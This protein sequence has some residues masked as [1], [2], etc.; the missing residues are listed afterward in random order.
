M[1][2]SKSNTGGTG[3]AWT[4]FKRNATLFAKHGGT[5][6]AAKA[7]AGYVAAMGG[8]AAAVAAAT[9][10]A[11][12]GQSL[13]TF[14]VGSSG[15]TGIVGGLEAVGLQ[16]LVGAD[17]F[18]V[19]SELLLEF[20]GSGGDLEAQAARSALLDV[21]DAILPED[22]VPLESVRLD[23][24]A[25]ADALCRYIAALVYNRAIPVIDERLTQLENPTLAQ[26]RNQE[27]LEYIDALV[28]LRLRD[29]SPLAIDWKGDQ[30]REFIDQILRAVYD[31]IEGWE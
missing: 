14:L 22:D 4:G 24:N 26:Q 5:D 16:R 2:T 30:G 12:T 19:L 17:R 18:T 7:L 20:A 8:V 11:R 1:G 27:L 23:E 6:R 10:G 28:R 13:G 3:G 31:Q 25:V 9:A 21:L 15:P 29:S